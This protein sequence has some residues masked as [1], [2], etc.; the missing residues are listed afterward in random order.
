MAL[1]KE[2]EEVKTV[3]LELEGKASKFIPGEDKFKVYQEQP[4]IL[5]FYEVWKHF[6]TVKKYILFKSVYDDPELSLEESYVLREIRTDH[7][8]FSRRTF[9]ISLFTKGLIIANVAKTLNPLALGLPIQLI[10]LSS[11]LYCINLEKIHEFYHISRYSYYLRL[12]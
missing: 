12:M 10:G 8:L 2:T 11:L 7:L 6:K 4:D 3:Q 1:T 9:L 5:T